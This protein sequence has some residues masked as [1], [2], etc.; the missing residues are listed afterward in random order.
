MPIRVDLQ[1]YLQHIQY[2]E[3]KLLLANAEYHHA[4]NKENTVDIQTEL[5]ECPDLKITFSNK[6]KKLEN[7]VNMSYDNYEVCTETY[8][9][10]TMS[11]ETT[12]Q[13]SF[14]DFNDQKSLFLKISPNANNNQDSIN[15]L[16]E[17]KN[18][19]GKATQ[20]N[21][22]SR[23]VPK[24]LKPNYLDSCSDWNTDNIK[25]AIRL[26]LIRNGNL[27]NSVV[28]GKQTIVIHETCAFDSL[29]NRN[30]WTRI[31]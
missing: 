16:N 25:S 13:P 6:T 21:S 11:L 27:C 30:G 29:T 22:T 2:I 3:G 14:T 8:S 1:V 5:N 17:V 23:I 12:P 24:H 4:I 15:S 9:L 18:W 19:R 28:I 7:T 20:Y 10:S 26:P 31:V